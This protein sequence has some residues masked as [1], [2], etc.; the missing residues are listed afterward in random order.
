[1]SVADPAREDPNDDVIRNDG[2]GLEAW[3]AWTPRQAAGALEGV[4]VPWCVVAGWAIDLFIGEQT[5]VHGD[6]EIEILCGDFPAVREHLSAYDFFAIGSGQIVALDL[7]GEWD[8]DWHQRWVLEPGP[9]KWR[10][11]LMLKP[12]DENT[13]VCRRDESI[14]APRS[15]IVETTAEGIPFLRPEA[16]LLYKAK[17]ARPKDE[18]DLTSCLPRMDKASRKWLAQALARVHPGHPWLARLH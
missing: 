4:D 6:L 9:R 12:G 17:A 11:D 10:V 5:R 3:D 14:T 1:M 18:A 16:V 8:A 13:W 7:E 2:P 15:E